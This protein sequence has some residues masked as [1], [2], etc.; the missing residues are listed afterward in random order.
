[1]RTMISS[2]LI[3]Y[4]LWGTTPAMSQLPPEVQADAYMLEVEQAIGDGNYD[5][6]WDRLQDIGRLQEDHDLDLPEFHFWSARTADALDLPEQALESVKEYLTAAGRQANHYVE[7]L[8][9]LNTLQTKV[10][11]E[12]WGADAYF[13]TATLEQVTACLE[14]GN[15]DLEAGNASGLTPLHAAAT[16]AEDPAVIEALIAAGADVN[17]RTEDGHTPLH[18]AAQ[19]NE[20]PAVL[21]ALLAAGANLVAEATGDRHTPVHEA[22][23]SNANPAVLAALLAAGANPMMPD[24][25]GGTLLHWAAAGHDNLAVVETLLAAGADVRARRDDGRTPLHFAASNNEAAVVE[26][27]IAVGANVQEGDNA[28]HTPLY[29]AAFGNQNPAVIEALIAAA[30]MCERTLIMDGRPCIWQ[31]GTTGIRPLSR[32]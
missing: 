13:E 15:V 27:L 10:S 29:Y 7:A 5:R 2:I 18:H 32:P 1:M 22:A 8:A 28:G 24:G 9:L 14:T 6:A 19:F 30:P 21:Q 4:T 23:K 12:G 3:L 26:A 20:E 16:D 25:Q 17:A 11:C 31:P